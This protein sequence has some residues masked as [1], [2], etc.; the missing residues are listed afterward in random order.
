MRLLDILPILRYKMKQKRIIFLSVFSS[1]LL[2]VMLYIIL[3]EIGHCIVAVSCGSNITEFSILSAHMSYSGGNYTNLSDLF[4]NANGVIFPLILS[5][6]YILLYRPAVKNRFYRVISF[7]FA[8]MPA[9][10]LLP[11]VF[12]PIA[13]RFGVVFAESDDTM[14]FL[15]NF[16]SYHDPLWVTAAALILIVISV[17]LTVKKEYC[18]IMLR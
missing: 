8:L 6:I 4:L 18:E 16:S 17:M 11:W 9:F 7:F 15:Y 10:S 3:H 2:C 1:V 13:Y 12:F 14:R 5:Y